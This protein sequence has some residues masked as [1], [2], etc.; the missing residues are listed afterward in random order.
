MSQF[1]GSLPAFSNR[2]DV[3][4]AAVAGWTVA[5]KPI[6]ASTPSVLDMPSSSLSCPCGRVLAADRP[7]Y[8]LRDGLRRPPLGEHLSAARGEHHRFWPISIAI[9]GCGRYMPAISHADLGL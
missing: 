6:A 5:A 9:L 8:P 4:S 7:G 1:C 2:S 3:T